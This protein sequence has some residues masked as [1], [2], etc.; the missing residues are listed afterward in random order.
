MNWSQTHRESAI[1]IGLTLLL[2]TLLL[3]WAVIAF[4]QE[5]DSWKKRRDD[6]RK[7]ETVDPNAPSSTQEGFV[8]PEDTYLLNLG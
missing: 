7:R 4:F 2:P 1:I 3:V 5:G 6:V 8:I